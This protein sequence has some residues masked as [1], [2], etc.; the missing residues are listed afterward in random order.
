MVLVLE[1]RALAAKGLLRRVRGND[2][3][4]PSATRA[5]P[6][7][8]VII[9]GVSSRIA[10]QVQTA[11]EPNGI[12]LRGAATYSRQFSL[13]ADG[14]VCRT[15]PQR[16]AAARIGEGEATKPARKDLGCR[17]GGKSLARCNGGDCGPIC[18]LSADTNPRDNNDMLSN[19][20]LRAIHGTASAAIAEAMVPQMTCHAKETP[21]LELVQITMPRT[22][23]GR[24]ARR[25]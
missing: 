14:R 12:F 22:A 8:I 7:R 2:P 16:S 17:F 5:K 20:A 19:H 15:M 3:L 1:R 13:G 24:I 10:V 4:P 11:T 25:K 21:R 6:K 18:F 9:D 23:V